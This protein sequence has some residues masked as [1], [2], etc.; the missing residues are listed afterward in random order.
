MNWDR[1]DIV[2]AHYA[3][4]TDYHG[5][6]NSPEYARLCRIS[7]YFRPG[8]L[9]RGFASLSENAQEIYRALEV[10][11]RHSPNNPNNQHTQGTGG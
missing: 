10:K 5:G 3:F 4:Y 7:R 11:H 6:Q 2:E 1:F 8:A 9:F